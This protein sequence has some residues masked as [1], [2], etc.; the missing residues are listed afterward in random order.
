MPI[1]GDVIHTVN[2]FQGAFT[3]ILAL[4]LGEALK[5]FASED[6][7]QSLHWERL[8]ALLTF[9]LIFFQFF[10]SMAEYFYSTYLSPKTA[11]EFVPGYLIFDGIMFMTQGSC[12]FTM[13]RSLAPQ[14]WQRFYGSVLVLM[15]IDIVWTGVNQIRGLH[16]GPW[17]VID[18]AIAAVISLMMWFE[19][20]KDESMRPGYIG[21][22]VIAVAAVLGY[23]FEHDMY[24]P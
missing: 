15:L 5:S 2:F 10:E 6:Q 8:P 12:F 14:R 13:S 17:L 16:V 20:G 23:W 21:L 22:A 7:N 11:L 19:R 24:F 18:I 3:I 4:A 9:M 1:R